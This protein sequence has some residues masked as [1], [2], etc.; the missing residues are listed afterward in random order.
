MRRESHVRFCEGLRVKFPRA[1][2]HRKENNE[3]HKL[4]IFYSE[5]SNILDGINDE[6]I[7]QRKYL[8]I[9]MQMI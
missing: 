8:T 5:I 7:I 2:L 3:Y 1:I 9:Q 4:K 6:L